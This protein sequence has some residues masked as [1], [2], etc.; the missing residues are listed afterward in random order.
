MAPH[1]TERLQ[2]KLLIECRD[3]LKRLQTPCEPLLLRIAKALAEGCNGREYASEDVKW[4]HRRYEEW[5]DLDPAAGF[6]ECRERAFV[7][8]IVMVLGE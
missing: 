7:D 4:L 3:K 2:G 1:Q 6:G 8:L 5:K